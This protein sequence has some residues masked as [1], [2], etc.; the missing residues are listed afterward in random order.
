MRPLCVLLL[1]AACKSEPA[2]PKLE[3]VEAPQ[4][5]DIAPLVALQLASAAHDHKQLLV[6]VGATWCEPCR[7][8]HE[9][10]AAGALDAEFGKLRLYVFDLDRDG[11]AL[12]K[13]G[14]KSA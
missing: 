14:Y 8:F 1:L 7:H 13:A 11:D 12:A 4:S 10:A 3:L 6:Y 2:P 9:A 5:A